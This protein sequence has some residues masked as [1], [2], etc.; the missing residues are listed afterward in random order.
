M[1]ELTFKSAGV[2]TRE[3]DLSGPRDT[4]PVG[5]PAG[6]IGTAL[7]GPAFVPLTFS[8]FSK[9][10]TTFGATDGEKFGPIAV[11][12]WLRN[13]QSC[14]YI[15]VLGAGDG[16]K[17][18][19]DTGN[20]TNAG[21]KV[22]DEIPQPNGLLGQNPYANK[23]TGDIK[24]RT[25]F[26]GCFMSES[27]GSTIFSEAGIQSQPA[28]VHAIR[29]DL[30]T[31]SGN[32]S[33][34]ETIDITIPAGYGTEAGKT[35]NVVFVTS[36]A[37][38]GP[39][40][41]H[42]DIGG[43]AAITVERLIKAINGG[44]WGAG[45]A[46]VGASGTICRYGSNFGS[47]RA[48][49]GLQAIASGT[50]KV[51]IKA[52]IAGK[53]GNSIQLEDKASNVTFS[54]ASPNPISLAGGA[55]TGHAVPILR[56]VLLAPSGV[57]L[58]LS[59]NSSANDSGAPVATAT[60]AS[61]IG[62]IVG[63]KGAHTGS[64]NLV[65]QEFVMLMNG[66]KATANNPTAITASFD[67]TAPNYFRNVFNTDPRNI[68]E[69]GHVLYGS[70][71][72]Y[73]TLAAVTGAGSISD[74]PVHDEDQE[75]IGFLLSS[76]LGRSAAATSTTVQYESFED[77]F[78]HAESPYVI[79]QGFGGP[80]YDLFK[81]HALS[82]GSGVSDKYKISIENLTVSTSDTA[83]YGTFDLL[84]RRFTDTDDERVVLESFRGLSLD[85]GSN[86]YIARAI[87]D[88]HI[89]YNFDNDLESQKII[90]DGS[91]PVRSRYVRVQM[92]DAM[93][94]KEVPESALPVG[95]RGPRHL[96]TSGSN[97]LSCT[98]AA[99]SKSAITFKFSDILLRA[100]TPPIP[101]RDTVA[102]GTGIKKRVDSRLYWGVQSTR[103]T[104][105]ET[106]N[107]VGLFDQSLYTYVKHFPK[108]RTDSISFS[109]GDNAGVADSSG[110]VL[111]SD[112][113]NNNKFSLEHIKIRTGSDQ[114][115]DPEYWLSASYVR[116]GTIAADETL[117]TRAFQIDDL[118]K[119]NNRKFV[120][121]TFPLQGGFDGVNIFDKEKSNLSN[122]AAKKEV[123]DTNQKGTAD[124]TVGSYRKAIDIMASKTDV[125][126]QLL[127]IP[128]MRHTSI[129]D[130]AMNA[131]EQRFDAVY[132][133]DI[134]E[135]DQFNLV[136]SSSDQRPHVA[137]T[138]TSFK[139]RSLDSSFTAAYFPDLVVTDPT[140]EALVA[141]PPSVAV[142]G[143]YSLNDKLGHPWFAP[144]GF[145][146]G[147]LSSVEMASVRLNR[148]NL[149]DL[150]DADINPITAFPGT[151]ITVWG[152]KT[153]LAAPS[154]LDRVNVRRLL[155]DV[156][157]KVKNVANSLLFEP[158]RV[159]TL[160]R[161]NALVN[162]ILQ[163]VQEQSGV[164]RFK[165]VIDTTTTTQA[166]VEN[167]TI[168]G[169]IFLQPTR[170]VEFVALDFVVTNAGS[171]I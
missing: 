13:A 89:F 90:V 132:L 112:R 101:Y 150:Y 133:M 56:G 20:V 143:A 167:N 107:K 120:K 8:S 118:A 88:Q 77:R 166:D 42:L 126:I 36:P 110:T 131:T 129:T 52:T 19:S 124:S 48:I 102:Q 25:Y 63:R 140:T 34:A 103:K 117:K 12:E 41:I 2:S 64:V 79:S 141:V 121:F 27:N 4:A 96:N 16:K 38:P 170:A 83:K 18:A 66:H 144:A 152:Q 31:F 163:T 46:G 85:P 28:N 70:Y 84:V 78:S 49:G 32:P 9:F 30:I 47:V 39:D 81:I 139:N 97:L 23:G 37:S 45:E 73:P 165:V 74:T 29:D 127:A 104:S 105:A 160:E 54:P 51:T 142:L 67:M 99:A 10:Q 159:E 156:R 61:A 35:I 86:R 57:I 80:N 75:P 114:V 62:R 60:A 154:A 82:D 15:R 135:R 55:D 155:I 59:G 158:N 24:G 7:E 33:N 92:S 147:A 87:G 113:F 95:Y 145:T 53:L 69:R 98:S 171:N 17:R 151:G 148:T 76:S 111:D 149:D 153:L 116:N 71:D 168:R 109:S 68:E 72:I 6:I 122:T 130:Y 100:V 43:T 137:N 146:R 3:I 108:H 134:E 40:Q 136:V 138:V 26:L 14:T 58:H 93:K 123:D 5:V 21:F 91:H 157:R 65:S 22:G 115:A 164:D 119:V 50:T 94:K 161:F 162:P 128:G 125:D 106:P 1:A 169:K 11:N 44:T